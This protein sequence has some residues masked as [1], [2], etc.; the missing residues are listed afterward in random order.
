MMMNIILWIAQFI[1]SIKFISSA[2]IHGFGAGRDSMKLGRAKYGATL[3][4]LLA[5]IGICTLL[6]SLSLVVPAVFGVQNWLTPIA[7]V[8]LMGL[9]LISIIFHISCRETPRIWISLILF[10]LA[11]F[12]AYGRWEWMVPQ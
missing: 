8:L 4:P 7:A 10:T 2:Y 9:T 1:L 3:K 12:V 5:V 11:G 6:C